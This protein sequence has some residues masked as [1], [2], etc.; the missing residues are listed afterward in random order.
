M[1]LACAN[2]ISEAVRMSTPSTATTSTSCLHHGLLATS[3]CPAVPLSRALN[4]WK[5]SFRTCRVTSV[6]RSRPS[7][8]PH[9]TLSDGQSPYKG[10]EAPSDPPHHPPD[11]TPGHF[12]P[13][14]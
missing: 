4:L 7:Q 3:L 8:G 2:L 6:L 9:G 12:S 14:T 13:P 1:S 11:P 5:C 10:H